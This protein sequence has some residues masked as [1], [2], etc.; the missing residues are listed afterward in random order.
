MQKD[1]L[2]QVYMLIA[3]SGSKN[4]CVTAPRWFCM[5][6][7]KVCNNKG[8]WVLRRSFT[9]NAVRP[10]VSGNSYSWSSTGIDSPLSWPLVLFVLVI[11]R[12]GGLHLTI[13][14]KART[15]V[16]IPTWQPWTQP[17]VTDKNRG[18]AMPVLQHAFSARQRL[19]WKI[20]QKK[21]VA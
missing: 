3:S 18:S 5:S 8:K 6:L 4:T 7:D 11:R 21:C 1:L 14:C 10:T 15:L 16:S 17:C 12:A 2:W 9:E 19:R 13:L 20:S